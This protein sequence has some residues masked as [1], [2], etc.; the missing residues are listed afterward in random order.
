MND[1]IHLLL[2]SADRLFGDLCNK[3][4]TDSADRS[5]WPGELWKALADC[6][7]MLAAVPESKGGAGL[8]IG[9]AFALLRPTGRYAVPLPVAEN[10]LGAALLAQAG[11]EIPEGP[12][13][14]AI[15][16]VGQGLAAVEGSGV[17]H[18]SGSAEVPWARYASWIVVAIV[19]DRGTLV[20]RIKRDSAKLELHLNIA[21]EPRDG[22]CLDGAELS[23]VEWGWSNKVKDPYALAAL[24]RSVLMAGALES[25]L[26]M[27]TEYSLERIQ[28]G[29]PIA[30]FQAVQQQIAML[31][32]ETAA[33][34]RASDSAMESFGSSYETTEI[35]IAK[36]RVG[37]AASRG[38]AIAHQVHGAMGFTHEHPLHRR[39]RRLWAWREEYGNEAYWN[40]KLGLRLA[41]IG[42]DNIWAFVT[43]SDVS[44]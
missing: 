18:L 2:E 19:S 17:V 28:F 21:G 10:L 40:R 5:E 6:G 9:E 16:G 14:L 11:V 41:S 44:G 4:V 1:T 39:T 12:L 22:V 38:A 8:P 20:G 15:G 32:G 24:S 25:V 43:R 23:G 3:S 13:S 34:I 35:A 27:C 26:S 29:R 37:E 7:L 36:S 42:A 30:K 33:A 31:A